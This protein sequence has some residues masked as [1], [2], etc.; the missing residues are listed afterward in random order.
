M[1]HQIKGQHQKQV[2]TYQ[3]MPR[4]T[5]NLFT[6][7]FFCLL[8]AI[9]VVGCGGNSV[10]A[11]TSNAV[12]LRASSN[13]AVAQT[14][15]NLRQLAAKNGS[16]R[17]IVGVRAAFA[18]EGLLSAPDIELQRNS[19]AAEQTAV[20]NHVVS[21]QKKLATTKL[22]TTIPFMAADAN[23]SE[24][25]A[26]LNLLE[27]T[28]IEEDQLATSSDAQSNPLIGAMAAW[29][30][31]YSGAGQTIAILDTG[32]DKTHPS[33]TGRVRAIVESGVQPKF[34]NHG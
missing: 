17:I 9:I 6:V 5:H 25:E 24:L 11:D 31:G 12:P 32:I 28:S 18:P 8:A 22:F 20:L 27:I 15:N 4:K 14:I 7:G 3:G 16:V 1:T 21:L 13:P 2:L 23:L 26:L 33:L 29:S 10:G 30:S 19:I 34:G